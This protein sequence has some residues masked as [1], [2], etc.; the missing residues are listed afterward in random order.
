MQTS[1]DTSKLLKDKLVIYSKFKLIGH[2]RYRCLFL[3]N[4][5]KKRQMPLSL[6]K[7]QFRSPVDLKYVLSLSNLILINQLGKDKKEQIY[8]QLNFLRD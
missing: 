5:K 8:G 7:H 6:S 3:C 1:E 4:E 2:M